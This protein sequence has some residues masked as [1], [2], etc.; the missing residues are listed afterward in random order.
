MTKTFLSILTATM[1]LAGVAVAGE[2]SESQMDMVTAGGDITT[3]QLATAI[4]NYDITSNA[5]H[6]VD[7][8]ANTY[9]NTTATIVVDER[10]VGSS[11]SQSSLATSVAN[12]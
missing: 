1:M 8:T 10:A 3:S 9:T 5:N 11:T 4:A 7:V 2:L 12:N 6:D